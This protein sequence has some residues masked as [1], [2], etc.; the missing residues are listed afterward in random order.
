MAEISRCQPLSP[1]YF[2]FNPDLK[3]LAYNPAEAKRLLR[4]AGYPN[5][6]SIEIEIPTGRYIQASDIVQ[7]IAAQ[8]S[9]VGVKVEL[10]EIEFG[11]WMNK[12]I[13]AKNLSDAAYFGLG[14]PTLDA[15]GLL[16]FWEKEN[17]Q[18]YWDNDEFTDAAKAAR[19]VNDPTK[20]TQMYRKLTEQLCNASPS[21]FLFFTPIT[22]AHARDIVWQARG[23]DWVRAFEIRQR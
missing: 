5:G 13:V 20:R 6:L 18:A 7:V 22:Y 23:D 21:I 2:G 14:W 17:P 8:L 15:G 12:Y 9:D 10:R 16:N 4:E 19:S 11:A 1:A 3:P